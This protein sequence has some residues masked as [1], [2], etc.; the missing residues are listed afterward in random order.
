MSWENGSI[1]LANAWSLFRRATA[2]HTIGW[3]ALALSLSLPGCLQ[4][5]PPS[6][7]AQA[8]SLLVKLLQDVR[9][10][11]RR[12]AVESL[13]KIGD[14][15]ATESILPLSRDPSALVR[16]AAITALGRL[17]PTA[18]EAVVLLLADALEDPVESVRQAAVVAIGE[19]EPRSQ[20]L[21]PIVALLQSSDP[22]IKKAAAQA[23]IQV[24]S[25][26]W[27]PQLIAAGHDPDAAVRQG[28]VAAVG[29][30]GGSSVAPWLRE[31][32]AQD[33]SPRVRAEAAYR[34]RTFSDLE[35]KA[36]LEAAGAKDANREVR[37][38][39]TEGP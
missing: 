5:S 17:K 14:P 2:S 24:D 10:E 7:K 9:P 11:M 12:T 23:L 37:R 25:S 30:S 21:Q 19:I 16:E 38:W 34:L 15:Q 22:N 6:S 1:G 20:L 33:P 26:Q 35:T 39:A 28:I 4:D 8:L 32:L 36:A 3:V 29:E 31:Y 13:G 18:T 27:I